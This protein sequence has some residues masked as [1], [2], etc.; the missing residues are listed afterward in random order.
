MTG[1]FALNDVKNSRVA[2]LL[3]RVQ[4]IP[5]FQNGAPG[6][7]YNPTWTPLQETGASDICNIM[8]ASWKLLASLCLPCRPCAAADALESDLAG[9]AF[10]SITFFVVLVSFVAG[11]GA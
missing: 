10:N 6:T 4:G 11:I 2:V 3:L 1:F 8:P 7:L 9:N 5:P